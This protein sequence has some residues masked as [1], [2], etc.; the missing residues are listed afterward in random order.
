MK[1]RG[2][3]RKTG[4]VLLGILMVAGAA[5]IAAARPVQALCGGNDQEC[6]EDY[7]CDPGYTCKNDTCQ[8]CGGDG[9]W[10]CYPDVCDAGNQCDDGR[11][12]AC[13]AEGE[14]CCNNDPACNAG[15]TCEN[16]T[17]QACGAKG[18]ACCPDGTCAAGAVCLVAECVSCGDGGDPCCAGKSCTVGLC[19]NGTC[20]VATPAPSL[21]RT[22]LVI[23][24]A[25]LATAGT[26]SLRRRR[27]KRLR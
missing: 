22:A 11:C 12:R 17:C 2:P 24:A 1:A 8:P 21:S 18:G 10:C 5:I 14:E 9:E 16:N 23:V 15:T 26:V 4:C 19:V 13:G 27:S 3:I 6:C 20:Q 25:L 7:T